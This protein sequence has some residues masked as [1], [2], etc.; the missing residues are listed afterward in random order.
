VLEKNLE[1]DQG[2]CFGENIDR[3]HR[4]LGEDKS[5]S[6]SGFLEDLS[7]ICIS[8]THREPSSRFTV[9]QVLTDIQQ[10]PGYFCQRCELARPRDSDDAMLRAGSSLPHYDVIS[11]LGKAVEGRKSSGFMSVVASSTVLAPS[12]DPRLAGKLT[13][14]GSTEVITTSWIWSSEHQDFYY[15]TRSHIGVLRLE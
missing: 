4:R 7:E 8:M 2:L 15:A 1:I 9:S 11:N 14:N 12:N 3:V 13:E 10:S 6:S 5:K